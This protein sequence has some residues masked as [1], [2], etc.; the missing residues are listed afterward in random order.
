MTFASGNDAGV[1]ELWSAV[2]DGASGAPEL[3]S[4][5]TARA[6]DGAVTS[7]S[8]SPSHRPNAFVSGGTDAR[9][10]F[11]DASTM[12]LVSSVEHAHAGEDAA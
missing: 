7:I 10:R 9:L 3:R 1:A 4:L 11:W 5:G 12:K 6:H 8:S 2:E